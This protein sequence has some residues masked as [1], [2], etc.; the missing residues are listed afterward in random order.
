MASRPKVPTRTVVFRV[1]RP[2]SSRGRG[3]GPQQLLVVVMGGQERVQHPG[4][5]HRL[6]CAGCGG[7]LV[8]SGRQC[9]GLGE[10]RLGQEASLGAALC[11]E[12]PACVEFQVWQE[13]GTAELHQA[14]ARFGEP[15][16]LLAGIPHSLA[17]DHQA[18]PET[19]VAGVLGI[20]RACHTATL[21]IDAQS[22]SLP[23]RQSC[24]ILVV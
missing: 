7:E 8:D 15:V 19:V 18:E 13:L 14:V 24:G 22:A 16:G 17:R 11:L 3:G 23:N 6:A 5:G 9:P 1:P 21:A 4:Q 2:M 20:D 12:K 10:H